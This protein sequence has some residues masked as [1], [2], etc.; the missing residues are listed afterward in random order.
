MAETESTSPRS[1]LNYL[2]GI[3]REHPFLGEFLLA[4]EQ[5]LLKST[6]TQP[7]SPDNTPIRGLEEIIATIS[8]LFVPAKTPP[9]F[10]PWLASWVAFSIWSDI[11][12]AKQREFIANMMELYRWR[13][14]EK[15]LL[16]LFK[17][18]TGREP[19]LPDI[20]NEEPHYFK[21]LLDLSELVRGSTESEENRQQVIARQIEI[22]HALIRLEKPAHTRYSLDLIFPSF[23]IGK[24]Q[25]TKKTKYFTQV[26]KNTRLGVAKWSN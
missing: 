20:T 8:D 24:Q 17:I 6:K 18:Y 11:S 19:T 15:N 26:G 22:A 12:E 23:R 2:P 7:N 14:T 16:K 25:G 3:Y 21:V 9:D 5:I 10:L 4:F 1:L 13:G